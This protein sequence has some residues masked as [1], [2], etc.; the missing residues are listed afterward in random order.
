M[1]P[2]T[3][4]GAGRAAPEQGRGDVVRLAAFDLD[5]TLLRG[6][7]VCEEIARG[8]D[9]IERMRELERVDPTNVEDVT[10][11]REEMAAW[12]AGLSFSD[13]RS[14]LTAVR[15]APGVDEGLALLRDRGFTIAIASLTWD[16]AVEWFAGRFGVDY[17]AGTRLSPDGRITH[18]WPDDKA[19]WLSGVAR[20]L[21][22]D[23]RNVAAVG[24]SRGDIP[25]LRA[26]GRRY[27][28]GR[29]R[30]AELGPDV[31]HEPGG[32]IRRVSSLIAEGAGR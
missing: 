29:T 21:G 22:A 10:A 13:L 6:A 5:G 15:V 7:S 1:L 18:F 11:M 16:F 4:A 20:E 26:V 19:R 9:R 23:M 25:M 8:L 32:D 2:D 27:W 12:Y 14:Y 31:V 28:V 30:P 24:D 17:W 3:A